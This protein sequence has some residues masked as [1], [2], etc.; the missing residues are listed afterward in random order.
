MLKTFI[1]TTGAL[2]L[3][4]GGYKYYTSYMTWYNDIP[5]YCTDK[6]GSDT[7]ID[8]AHMKA[9]EDCIDRRMG[10]AS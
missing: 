2:V 9:V 4:L 10:H 7:V 5:T 3:V 1:A 6:Y 8:D